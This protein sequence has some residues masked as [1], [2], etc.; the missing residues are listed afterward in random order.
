MLSKLVEWLTANPT[1]S[2]D[3]FP[4]APE[5]DTGTNDWLKLGKQAA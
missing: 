3:N 5:H 4:N 1:E 2:F